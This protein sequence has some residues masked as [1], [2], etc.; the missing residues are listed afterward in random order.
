MSGPSIPPGIPGSR[1]LG[2]FPRSRRHPTCCWR[3]WT[4][5]ASITRSS[6][7]RR[8]MAAIT[9]SCS[10]RSTPT[11]TATC[12]W[13][14]STRQ[15]R[16]PARTPPRW[17]VTAVWGYGSTWPW[18]FSGPRPRRTVRAGTHSRLS[19]CRSACAQRPSTMPWCFALSAAVREYGS[20]ST[21]S[22]CPRA[23]LRRRR[24]S[25]SA[26]T[27]GSSRATLKVA[28]L[29]RVSG[30]AP[31]HRD[32]W[33]LVEAALRAFGASRLLWGSDFPAV[34]PDTGYEGA[35]RADGVHVLHSRRRP[36]ENHG[37]HVPRALGHRS[38]EIGAV[39]MTTETRT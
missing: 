18:I 35:V 20:S 39:T 4:G 3:R 38:K 5:S 29:P 28:G 11:A 37:G 17:C 19:A 30:S 16:L 13:G 2:S 12:L 9:G 15:S 32:A 7:S 22:V 21:I 10:T 14:S 34:D 27:P 26:T 25:G 8:P 33:P 31:P 24:S 6:C 23:V 1:R 36:G